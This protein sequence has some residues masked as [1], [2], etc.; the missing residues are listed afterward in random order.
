MVSQIK[1]GDIVV[2][3]VLKDIKNVYLSVYPPTGQVR[4][5]AP[6]HLN[7][8]TVRIFAVSKLEWIQQ[9]TEETSGPGPRN[10]SRIS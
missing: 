3:V 9:Q 7:I 6:E 1:L 5:T 2:D 4:I 10:Y 8:D